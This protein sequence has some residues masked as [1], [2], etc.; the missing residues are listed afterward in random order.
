MITIMRKKQRMSLL[1]LAAAAVFLFCEVACFMQPQ[2]AYAENGGYIELSETH[3]SMWCN[4]VDCLTGTVGKYY[5]TIHWFYPRIKVSGNMYYPTSAEII[6]ISGLPEGLEAVTDSIDTGAE[7]GYF[8]NRFKGVPKK[9][10][11]YTVKTIS[12]VGYTRYTE[13]EWPDGK[14]DKCIVKVPEGAKKDEKVMTVE[15]KFRIKINDADSDN[16]SKDDDDD[17]DNS[18]SDSGKSYEEKQAEAARHFAPDTSTMTTEQSAGWSVVSREAPSVSSSGGGVSAVSAYQGPMCRLAFQ[19]A[20][21][22]YSL[23]HTYDMSFTN[24]S[25]QVSMKVPTD[26]AKSGRKFVM[27]F[28]IGGRY[29]STPELTAD[30]NGN[31]NFDLA[32]LGLTAVDSN[33]AMAIMYQD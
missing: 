27:T 8:F 9:S 3:T 30:A 5:D 22:G 28:V 11:E 13:M 6:K 32:A 19:M 21:P 14:G 23:G 31:I 12:K 10:G 17:D 16:D 24:K 26:L 15:W 1:A 25:G 2:K 33:A 20:A 29:V 7:Y 4:T 18:S